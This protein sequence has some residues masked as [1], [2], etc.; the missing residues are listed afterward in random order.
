MKN[1]N[2]WCN[3]TEYFSTT[4][5]ASSKEEA[6]EKAERFLSENGLPEKRNV[7]DRTYDAVE[8]EKE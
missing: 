7:Y 3:Y 1:F 8:A 6:I 5:Q 2:V 4:V